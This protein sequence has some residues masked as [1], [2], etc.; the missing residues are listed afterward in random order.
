[1]KKLTISVD[2]GGTFT[3][4]VLMQGNRIKKAFKIPTSVRAPADA[5]IEGIRSAGLDHV[6][7]VVHATTIATNSILGQYNL[8]LPKTA[9]LTTY[10]FADVIEIGRQNR[11]S[12]YDLRFR[13][14]VPIVPRKLRYEV[15]ERIGPDGK[16]VR[17]A[18]AK[19]LEKVV[20][21]LSAKKVDTIAISFLHS[22][23]NPINEVIAGKILR[24]KF[25]HVSLSSEISAEPR[26]FERT[27]TA[28]V[29]AALSP[30]MTDYLNQ[31]SI[32]LS[33]FGCRQI[34]MMSNSGGL[35]RL[36]DVISKPIKIIESGPTAGVI[37]ANEFA[38]IVGDRNV[39]SFDM[40][41]TTAKASAIVANTIAT[42]A[43]YEVGGSSN[44]GRMIK[45]TGYPVRTQFVDIAEVSAGG[46]TIIWKDD[47]GSLNIGP[48]SAG[49]DPGPACYGLGGEQPTITDANLVLGYIS[50][51]SPGRTIMLDM[52]KAI[53][54]LSL[55][56]DP[57]KVAE[58][59]ISLADLEMARAIR[60]VTYERG[61]DPKGFV[62]YAFGGAGPQH[63]ARVAKLL[64]SSEVI[65]PTN[66]AAFSAIG[67]VE[68]DW[69][70]EESMAFP[71]ELK[72]DY[73]NLAVK[74][75]EMEADI[76]ISL[77]A[78]CRYEGQGADLSVPVTSISMAKIKED[79]QTIHGSTYG[80]KLP[81]EIEI[82]A[83]RVTGTRSRVKPGFEKMPAGKKELYTRKARESGK[84]HSFPVHSRD[85]LPSGAAIKGPAMIDEPGTSTLVPAGWSSRIGS[86]GEIRMVL[87]K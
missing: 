59:A 53:K 10:G 3:D 36:H 45:G 76:A 23:L 73:E 54:S 58:K 44:H 35:M 85:S 7:E 56:G 80:F 4:I 65:I 79:F 40:G 81:R 2:I 64:G 66:P 18:D 8:E 22:Y 27:S 5:V 21:D 83:I 24:K 55:L 69:K 19:A 63:A 51:E 49:S 77:S 1:M 57:V 70:Y 26:E 9:L 48:Q 28:V 72:A 47:A 46:G 11:P 39:I 67:L 43:E 75:R 78:D 71:T 29:N 61:L 52:E 32:S 14:P 38:R 15:F 84:W 60:L 74:L 13:K 34:S 37:A 82:S 62:L 6:D 25:G 86:H 68:A 41:G 16:V 31:L 12:I 42:T 20:S 17:A 87:H 30:I 33:K 50:R